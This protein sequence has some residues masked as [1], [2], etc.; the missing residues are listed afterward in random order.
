[1]ALKFWFGKKGAEQDARGGAA[2]EASATP[3]LSKDGGSSLS[4]PSQIGVAVPPVGKVEE[5][6]APP[7]PVRVPEGEPSPEPVPLA[8]ADQGVQV[9]K[10]AASPAP[11]VGPAMSDVAQE[12]TPR[13]V[14]VTGVTA[15]GEVPKGVLKP[16]GGLVRLAAVPAVAAAS[17]APAADPEAGRPVFKLRAKA[18]VSPPSPVGDKS[19]I[20]RD[21][22][23]GMI[24]PKVDQRAL[25]YQLMNGLYDAVLVLD[26]QGH[27]VDCNSRVTE[28]LGY[29]RE[30]AWDLPIDKVITGMSSQM[31]EHLKRN[32]AENHHIL[33]DACC[34]RQDGTSFASEVG[35]STL[36]LTRGSNVVFAIRN[37]ERRKSAMEELRKSRVALDVALAPAFV[38]DADGFFL[39]V[40]QALLDTFG[41]PDEA[42]A[43]SVRLVDL[44]PDAARFFLR[45]ACGEKLRE[46]LRIVTPENVSVQIELSLTPVQSGQANT[47]IAGSF[48]QV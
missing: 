10:P 9:A 14:P 19:G 43:K 20:E 38:C 18:D 26:D 29:S 45:A 25:Y 48:L 1:M 28:M 30:E 16:V 23:D 3:D 4:E 5:P 32:L 6:K 39:V 36:F 37:V 40:N 11:I 41:I 44:L 21:A 46:T 33:I 2:C 13:S 12:A 35:V 8:A 24:R 7:S 22:G 31:F 42:K 27:V 47:N 17:A 34:F 15:S